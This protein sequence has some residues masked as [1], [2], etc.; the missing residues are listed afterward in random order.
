MA[1]EKLG[2]VVSKIAAE[3]LRLFQYHCVVLKS[4]GIA[5][6]DAGT[7]VPFGILQN[8]P[9]TGEEAVVAPIG[10]GGISKAVAGAAYPTIGQRVAT[11]YIGAADAGKVQTLATAQFPLGICMETAAAEDDVITVLLTP[12]S[13]TAA[14]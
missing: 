14:F 5:I 10:C 4:T 2:I 9:N 12:M 3:D 8:T 7:D 1:T 11:E 6:V 13:T